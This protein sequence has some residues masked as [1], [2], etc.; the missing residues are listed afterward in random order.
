MGK[1]VR[2]AQVKFTLE[3]RNGQFE[4]RPNTPP[5]MRKDAELLR[6]SLMR[7]GVLKHGECDKKQLDG[8]YI[9]HPFQETKLSL[10]NGY[11][12]YRF[13]KTDTSILNA[14]KNRK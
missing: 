1:E 11:L 14:L 2:R 5:F 3:N 6:L 8:K 4:V 10:Y 7:H 12:Q 9:R 13:Q